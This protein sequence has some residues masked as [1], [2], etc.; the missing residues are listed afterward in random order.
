MKRVV[1]KLAWCKTLAVSIALNRDNA[2]RRTI[3]ETRSKFLQ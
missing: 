1:R 3:L 2:R